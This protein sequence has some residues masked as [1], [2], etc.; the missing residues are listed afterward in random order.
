MVTKESLLS[1]GR[2]TRIIDSL[3]I[4]YVGNNYWLLDTY[5]PILKVF[6]PLFKYKFNDSIKF[7]TVFEELLNRTV[8]LGW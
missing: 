1:S 8:Y 2:S 5:S 3:Y 4:M 7:A 6:V